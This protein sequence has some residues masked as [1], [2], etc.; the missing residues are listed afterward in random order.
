[1]PIFEFECEECGAEFEELV[2]AGTE[3]GT[4]PKCGSE[5][6]R[7][8]WS[9]PAAPYKLVKTPG[10]AR[11]Q[12]ARNAKLKD[13]TKARFK[14]QRQKQRDARAAREKGGGGG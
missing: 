13:A 7:R 9:A 11:Q 10:A 6:S 2:A 4:C 12:E 3:S 1:M 8:L 5:R 14:A